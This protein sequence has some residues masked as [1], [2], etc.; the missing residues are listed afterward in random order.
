MARQKEED[1]IVLD[2]VF[3]RKFEYY[4]DNYAVDINKKCI[5]KFC[6]SFNKS[7]VNDTTNKKCIE[8]FPDSFNKSIENDIIFEL[9]CF[10][11]K[12]IDDKKPVSSY[13]KSNK[14]YEWKDYFLTSQF[15]LFFGIPSRS[16]VENNVSSVFSNLMAIMVLVDRFILPQKDYEIDE[17]IWCAMDKMV[18]AA[19]SG[20]EEISFSDDEKRNLREELLGDL[21][22]DESYIEEVDG[23]F[24]IKFPDRVPDNRKT[25]IR[26]KIKTYSDKFKFMQESSQRE[27]II[28][29]SVEKGEVIRVPEYLGDVMKGLAY[30]IKEYPLIH[31]RNIFKSW[32]AKYSEDMKMDEKTFIV[33]EKIIKTVECEKNMNNVKNSEKFHN[34]YFDFISKSIRIGKDAKKMK[35]YMTYYL[36]EKLYAGNLFYIEMKEIKEYQAYENGKILEEILKDVY[37]CEGVFC[38]KEAAKIILRCYQKNQNLGVEELESVLKTKWGIIQRKISEKRKEYIEHLFEKENV[39]FDI[40]QEK[41]DFEEEMWE[42][43]ENL[44]GKN[45]LDEE[46]EWI[47][48]S[49]INESTIWKSVLDKNDLE[50]DENYLGLDENDCLYEED[51]LD[52]R[53]DEEFL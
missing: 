32:K 2:Y 26:E 30:N 35:K 50:L 7:I 12:N 16:V 17:Y 45:N 3:P 8:E 46:M 21:E 14:I 15:A 37:V 10:Y 51:E 1:A 20:Q 4:E 27:L 33:L 13:L 52:E 25:E 31:E 18:K 23:I 43:Y 24:F 48:K 11:H 42:W 36:H 9:L 5:K 6:D 38:R 34:K 28:T 44:D 49:S 47:I 40:L 22:E 29:L 19:D 53:E 41:L 39:S